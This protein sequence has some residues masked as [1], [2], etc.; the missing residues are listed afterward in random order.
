[1]LEKSPSSLLIFVQREDCVQ[2]YPGITK[3]DQDFDI[4]ELWSLSKD[5]GSIISERGEIFELRNSSGVS[6]S[7][8]LQIIFKNNKNTFK[9]IAPNKQIKI[10]KSNFISKEMLDR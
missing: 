4:E 10:E 2:I 3:V 1:M 7:K 9:W 8:S 5:G 6:S